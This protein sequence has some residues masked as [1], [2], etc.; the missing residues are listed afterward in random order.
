MSGTGYD[1]SVTTF[2]PDGRV[3]QVEYAS[4]AVEKSGTAIGVRCVD[5][6]VLGV[7]KLILSKMLVKGSN[8]RIFNCDFHV[9]MALAGLAADARQLANHAR[10]EAQNYRSFYG[11]AIPGTVLAD[12]MAQHMHSYTLYSYMR[13]YGVSAL[14]A[15]FDEENGPQLHAIEPSGVCHRYF[16]TASGKNK[17]GA[18]GELEKLDFTKITCREAIKEVAKILY[19]LHDDV[20]DKP[21]E[22]ELSWV[23]DESKRKH[24]FV[25]EELRDEA[26]KAA[27]A[28]KEAAEMDSDEDDA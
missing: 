17:Q 24:V 12:R 6:V 28:A 26:F 14:F 1:L 22:L 5:G 9:G 27:V 8:K 11:S 19:K 16:A 20:K 21:M 7:E 2:S 4:K 10:E 23:C 18:K 25:P 15:S 3:F 13:P